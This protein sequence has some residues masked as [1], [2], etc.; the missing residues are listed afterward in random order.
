MDQDDHLHIRGLSIDWNKISPDSYLRGIEAIAG[1]KALSFQKPVTFFVGENGSG[2]STLLEA[3]AIAYGFNPEGGTKNYRF[4]TYDSHSELCGAIRLVRGVCRP[5]WGYFLRA[6]SFYNVASAEEEYSRGPGGRPG[7]Y[8]EKSHG[9]SFLAVTHSNLRPNGVY[10]MDEP[11]AA[12]S[13]QRQLTLL[14]EIAGCAKEHSQFIIATHSPILLGLPGAQILSFDGG[15][16][17][18]C[19]YEDTESYQVAE[20]FI[21]N[22]EQIL[23]RLLDLP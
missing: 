11:E 20:M 2:K 10:L 12:L 23:R 16:I 15:T 13:L 1:L 9:E 14:L 18:E 3:V 7:H 8:H 6:E 21:N 4:S 19:R 22:R 5:G 17:H